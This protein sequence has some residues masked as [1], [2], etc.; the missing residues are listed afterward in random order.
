[1]TD[2]WQHDRFTG[3]PALT[4]GGQYLPALGGGGWGGLAPLFRLR[5][6]LMQGRTLMFVKMKN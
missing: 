6:K 1:M 5:A 3:R 2:P 4:T